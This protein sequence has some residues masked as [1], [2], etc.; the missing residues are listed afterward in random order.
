MCTYP[1]L[2]ILCVYIPRVVH[3]VCVHTPWSLYFT[4]FKTSSIL[5][6][7]N[8]VLRASVLLKLYF[9]TTCN[10][11][12]HFNNPMGGLKIDGS[13]HKFKRSFKIFKLA[14]QQK[15]FL[16]AVSTYR[17]YGLLKCHYQCTYMYNCTSVLQPFTRTM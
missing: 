9:K 8:C 17:V 10:I 16:P 14:K 3:T 4:T 7:Q 15:H 11:R 6:L 5:K 12:P 1:V 2:Y 13:L